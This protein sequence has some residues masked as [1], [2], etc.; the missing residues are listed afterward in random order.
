M[1]LPKAETHTNILYGN[2]N[3][4]QLAQMNSVTKSQVIFLVFSDWPLTE[5]S[6]WSISFNFSFEGLF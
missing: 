1:T 3:Y 4:Q 6:D 2:T 5:H